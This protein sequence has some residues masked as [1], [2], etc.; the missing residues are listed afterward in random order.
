MLGALSADI[1]VVQER[2][3]FYHFHRG[4]VATVDTV[5]EQQMRFAEAYPA[6]YQ[7]TR[8][9][10]HGGVAAVHVET[11]VKTRG[12]TGHHAGY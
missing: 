4:H 1:T 9:R 5:F 7:G 10:D 11:D 8:S 2:V 3:Q 6:R 12:V